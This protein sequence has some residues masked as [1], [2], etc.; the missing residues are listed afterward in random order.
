MPIISAQ[1]SP[2]Q[3]RL[4]PG[5]TDLLFVG[6]AV[7]MLARCQFADAD[8]GWHLWAGMDALAHGPRAIPDTLSFTRAGALWRDSSWLADALFAWCYRHAGYFGVSLL[9]SLLFAG[10][11]TWLYRILLGE[12]RQVPA[13]LTASLLA[14]V[15]ALLQTMARPVAFT[16]ALV[17]AAWELVRVPGRARLALWLLPP[18]A[19]LWANLHPSAFL[20]PGL[21]GFAW[22]TRGRDRRLGLAALLSLAALGATPWGFDWLREVAPAGRNL[23]ILGRI[24]EWQT[25]R[26]A[27]VRFWPLLAFLL[28]AVTARRRGPRLAW[29]EALMGVACL[30]GSL[31]AVRLGP[32]AAI[33][34]APYLARDLAGWAGGALSAERA[35]LPARCWRA[36]Q[37]SLAPFEAV[38][39]PGLWP[40]LLGV[41]SLALAPVLSRALPGAS[42]GFPA[43][44]F[45]DRAMA[46]ADS[47]DLGPRV[48]NSYGWGGYIS[49]VYGG[50][51]KVFVDGRAGFFA[52]DVLA[53]YFSMLELRPGW[54][55]S[56]R[57]RHPDWMLLE[58]G[59]PLVDAAPLTG[60]WRVAYRDS[61]AEILTPIPPPGPAR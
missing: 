51:W 28:L 27:E 56:L 6:L 10:P 44:S 33:L 20:A 31:L 1:L 58:R 47:L 60:R 23:A 11:F 9:V 13:A 2:L 17:L 38:F 7:S 18:L 57:R 50:R 32:I 39:R 30:T 4:V 61:L 26:F 42:L 14:M 22:L 55:E 21:A 54:Q 29:G 24:D 3:R 16:F 36:A 52:G 41:L 34:W 53:D 43:D 8:S 15:V 59:A 19:A 48:L 25:P 49:W 5:L 45:P 35:T 37:E 46:V 12:S 40:A